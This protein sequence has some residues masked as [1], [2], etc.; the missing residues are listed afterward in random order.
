MAGKMIDTQET[1]FDQDV[2]QAKGFTLVDFWAEWCGPCRM[3]MPALEDISENHPLR[4][5]KVNVDK[6]PNIAAQYQIK[7]L[8]TLILFQDGK[9]VA[10]KIG[11]M[12]KPKLITWLQEGGVELS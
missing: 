4:M 9:P 12:Q 6:C 11:V 3:M 5:V 2:I 10:T 8:P 7:S 1:T